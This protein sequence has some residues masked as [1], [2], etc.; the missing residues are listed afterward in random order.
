MQKQ[1]NI[2]PCDGEVYYIPEFYPPEKSQ[3]IYEVLLKE[4]DWEEKTIKIFGR[5]VMQPRKIAW[6]GDDGITYTYS[7][8]RQVTKPWIPVLNDLRQK[9]EETT[10]RQF[11]S[12]LLNLYRSDQDSMGWHSDD[13]PELGE[14]PFIASLS[15]GHARIFQLKHKTRPFKTSLL[16]ESGSLL[17]MGGSTQQYWKHQ[18]PKRR[19][20]CGPRINLTFRWVYEK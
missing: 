19:A 13:E 10:G 17:L 12:V 18:L 6:Y 1:K 7:N 15:F 9:V 8:L 2:L 14:Q 3:A 11:N 4:V 5:E 20:L 16:L